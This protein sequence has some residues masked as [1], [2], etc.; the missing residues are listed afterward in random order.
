MTELD[1]QTI[2]HVKIGRHKDLLNIY[3]TQMAQLTALIAEREASV[4]RIQHVI[5]LEDAKRVRAFNIKISRAKDDALSQPLEVG[6]RY[7]SGAE[8][9]TIKALTNGIIAVVRES[10]GG[11][12]VASKSLEM[13]GELFYFEYPAAVLVK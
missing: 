6:Q 2:R 7:R 9:F 13:L 1:I 5:D 8:F 11:H 10:D 12:P 4:A 3:K